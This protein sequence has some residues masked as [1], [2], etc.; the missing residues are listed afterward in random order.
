MFVFLRSNSDV[1][2]ASACELDFTLSTTRLKRSS[3]YRRPPFGKLQ[4]L[5]VVAE[6]DHF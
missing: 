3:I 2:F 1:V 5:A 4:F 6:P